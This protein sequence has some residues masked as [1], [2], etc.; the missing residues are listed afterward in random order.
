MPP[1]RDF[2]KPMGIATGQIDLAGTSTSTASSSADAEVRGNDAVELEQATTPEEE[3]EEASSD[4]EEM[5]QTPWSF[6]PTR[7][8]DFFES[9]PTYYDYISANE[10][11]DWA[12]DV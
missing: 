3:E 5:P 9:T 2:G 4:F 1:E 12:D 6:E 11:D 10:P 8:D 7:S